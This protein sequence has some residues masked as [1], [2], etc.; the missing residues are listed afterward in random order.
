MNS[1]KT[2]RWA[3][4]IGLAGLLVATATTSLATPVSF[5]LVGLNDSNLTASVLFAYNST[6]FTVDIDVKNTSLPAAGP[7]PRITAF[8]FNVPFGV[9][10]VASFTGPGGWADTFSLNGINTP[11]SLGFFDIG[12]ITGP[13]F[14]GG[15]AAAGIEVDDTFSFSFVLTGLGLG[16]FDESSFL[17]EPSFDAP[18]PPHQ[19]TQSFVARF[20]QT[21]FDEEGS[22]VAIPAPEPGVLLLLGAGLGALGIIRPRRT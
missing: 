4:T 17:D 6:T 10:G 8:A 7:D 20:Q 15:Q 19:N 11:G 14:N 9:T 1:T 21:G 13:N 2:R 18:G 22:D 3:P 16:T 12:G 5:D